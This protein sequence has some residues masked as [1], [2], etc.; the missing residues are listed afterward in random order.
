M[1]SQGSKA[2]SQK[3][4]VGGNWIIHNYLDITCTYHKIIRSCVE[5]R[6]ECMD[7]WRDR[8]NF[9]RRGNKRQHQEHHKSQSVYLYV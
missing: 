6:G 2:G 9:L 1:S 4:Y 5:M 7:A 3:G 8:L